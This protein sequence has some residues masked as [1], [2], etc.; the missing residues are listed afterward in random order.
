MGT[1]PDGILFLALLLYLS[2]QGPDPLLAENER[3]SSFFNH[4][5]WFAL[6]GFKALTA[7][8]SPK[9]SG[10]VSTIER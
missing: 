4:F 3:G 10:V 6:W 8:D 5:A 9:Q 1:F 7:T 2:T